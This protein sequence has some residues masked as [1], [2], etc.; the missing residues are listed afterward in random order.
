MLQ[1]WADVVDAWVAGEAY[2]PRLLPEVT[3][4]GAIMTASL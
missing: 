2:A 4:R 1:E 3:E